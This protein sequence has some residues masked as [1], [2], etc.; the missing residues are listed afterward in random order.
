M[1]TLTCF[2]AKKTYFK[3]VRLGIKK[4]LVKSTQYIY[5]KRFNILKSSI[6][7][8]ANNTITLLVILK[9]AKM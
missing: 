7:T 9:M 4:T 8:C 6:E 5:L 1:S 2:A 3:N